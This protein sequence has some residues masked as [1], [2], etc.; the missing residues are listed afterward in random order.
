MEKYGILGYPLSHSISPEIH[1][2]AFKTLKIDA[3]YEK[4]EINPDHFD[5]KITLL[6]KGNW[7][8]F[9]VTIPFKEKIIPHLDVIDPISEKIG[10]INTVKI[11]NGKWYG[12]NTDYLGFIRPLKEKIGTVDTVLMIG[13]GG[14][15]KGVLYGLLE[16]TSMKHLYVANR[17]AH[18][19]EDLVE[20]ILNSEVDIKIISL[21]EVYNIEDSINLI[22][23]TTNVG[24][25]SLKDE[26][27][28]EIDNK[29]KNSLIY[30]LIYNPKKTKLLVLS[31]M[32]GCKT[33]NGLPMLIYQADESFKIW[34]GFHFPQEVIDHFLK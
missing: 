14:A 15:A 17:T 8:G 16:K 7:S 19:A 20:P 28:I 12:Y 18:R 25:G 30:D 2:L 1:N 32:I 24:M 26:T 11:I 13:A 22:I 34:T 5:D 6:K 23:N 9:N 4:I 29:F 3:Y 27:P 21:E 33:I 10:A 31:E